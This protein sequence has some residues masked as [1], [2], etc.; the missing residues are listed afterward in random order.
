MA[1]V[2]QQP[3]VLL[4]LVVIAV[5]CCIGMYRAASRVKGEP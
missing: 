1:T 5:V 3:E 4:P 2:M